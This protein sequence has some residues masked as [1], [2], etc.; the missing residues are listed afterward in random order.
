M[1]IQ[2]K[3]GIIITK[4]GFFIPVQ[5]TEFEDIDWD[6]SG[7]VEFYKDTIPY[8]EISYAS[9][10]VCHLCKNRLDYVYD[11]DGGWMEVNEKQMDMKLEGLYKVVERMCET[12]DL[13]KGFEVRIAKLEAIIQHL[14][15]RST[16][17]E[18]LGEIMKE[19]MD[20][21]AKNLSA[22]SELNQQPPEL[23]SDALPIELTAVES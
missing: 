22:V 3:D 6:H 16:D 23:Q 2:F 9:F 14:A 13:I 10:C 21:A 18:E 4:K 20:K 19:I 15:S 1:S 7:S 8:V 5:Y 17:M 12:H 11:F